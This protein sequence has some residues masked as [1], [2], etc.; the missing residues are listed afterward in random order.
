M[1]VQTVIAFGKFT[2][3]IIGSYTV[4]GTVFSVYQW[5]R[6]RSGNSGQHGHV[7]D[8]RRIDGPDGA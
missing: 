5:A 7:D 8:N 3:I 4:V 6:D 2:L 1:D